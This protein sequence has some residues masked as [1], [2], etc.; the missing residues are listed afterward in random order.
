[1]K[2]PHNNDHNYHDPAHIDKLM[3]DVGGA[4][5]DGHC[6]GGLRHQ[7]REHLEAHDE[8]GVRLVLDDLSLSIFYSLPGS[9]LALFMY[10]DLLN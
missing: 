10:K 3:L 2:C 5:E 6:P 7:V 4:A 1:M 8:V 9:T